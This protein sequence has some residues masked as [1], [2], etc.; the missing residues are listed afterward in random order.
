M[1]RRRI[2]SACSVFLAS[3]SLSCCG[4]AV[5]QIGEI[6]D[7]ESGNPARSLELKI[8]EKIFC[9]LQSAV[10]SLNSDKDKKIKGEFDDPRN[11]GHTV[12]FSR[13]P[14]PET[15]GAT[16][17]LTLTVEELSAL[18]PGVSL[19]TPIHPAIT[20]F[21]GEYLPASSTP[22][23]AVTYPL[24]STPQT[25]SFGFGGTLSSDATRID[26]YTFYYLIKDLETD[27]PDCRQPN[28][29]GQDP[30][31]Y[32]G[33]SLLLESDLGIY[34][35]LDS[36]RF[37]RSSLGVSRKNSQEV[38]SYDVKF[39]IVSSG[40]VTPTWKLVRVSSGAGSLPLFN[41]KRERIHEMLLTFGPTADAPKGGGKQPSLLSAND[42]LAQQIGSAVGAA[43]KNALS[44]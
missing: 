10:Y 25:Y 4:I 3:A 38:M 23:S 30:A 5:P 19:N 42:A 28:I 9:E 13:N 43:V 7:D 20:N 41:T 21:S 44:Q 12:Q 39:D 33:S 31:H 16:L 11:P 32:Q 14:I 35:W 18:N 29:D 15:W 6:W 36:T 22:L 17:T 24:L 1:N 40:N 27:R 26:K 37:I 34:N 2:F 8:K